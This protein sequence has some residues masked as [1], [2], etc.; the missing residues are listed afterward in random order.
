MILEALSF[1]AYVVLF[2]AVFVREGESS[3]IGW[4]ESYLITMTGVVATR[5]FATAGAG[6][7]A[8]T[9]WALRRSGMEARLVACRMVAF[10][11]LLYVIYAASLVLAGVG[12]GTGLFPGGGSFAITIVPA[13]VGALLLAVG[14]AVALLPQDFERRLERWA[15]GSGVSRAGRR[16][17]RRRRR[18][19]PAGCARRSRWCA[20]AT[21]VCWG[22]PRGGALKSACCGRAFT[23]S[24]RRRRSR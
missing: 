10:L 15:E 22:R 6:G 23:P 1:A 12:L 3:R 16:A 11:V 24:A 5:L 4:R 13:I 14:G 19:R 8:L 21:P 2:Q 20:R 9:A 7:V 17:W 18:W